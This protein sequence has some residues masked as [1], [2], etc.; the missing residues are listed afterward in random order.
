MQG[1]RFV[2]LS[3]LILLPGT[4]IAGESFDGTWSTT[5]TCPPKGNTLGYTW[6]F[7]SVIQN[8]VLHGERGT[9]EEPGAFTLDGR[10]AEDG[11]AKLAGAGIVSS[12]EYA[13]G[14]FAH[15][16]GHYSYEVKARFEGTRGAGTKS[17]GLG[18]EGRVCSFDFTKQPPAGR[19][20]TGPN[21]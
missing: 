17:A 11:T 6:H 3:A 15:E 5:L 19:L 14:V 9:A 16:G 7:L 21:P 12:R 20:P 8:N 2:L 1:L 13:R 4:S 18:I 10:L